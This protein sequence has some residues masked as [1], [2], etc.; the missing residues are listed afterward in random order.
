MRVKWETDKTP[1][2]IEPT[3]CYSS[4]NYLYWPIYIAGILILLMITCAIVA[5]AFNI[6]LADKN[7]YLEL[8]KKVSILPGIIFAAFIVLTLLAF[9]FWWLF[10]SPT[11]VP[12][13][14]QSNPNVIYSKYTKNVVGF[15]DSNYKKVD[16]NKVYNNKVPTEVYL[17]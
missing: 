9:M 6:Y 14:N 8:Q 5:I 11:S 4:M 17:Q 10:K 1:G 7:D 3:C 13:T 15:E 16:L 12:R 2:Y